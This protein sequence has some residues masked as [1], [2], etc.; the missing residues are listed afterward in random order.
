MLSLTKNF[1]FKKHIG[2]K[3]KVY[4]ISFDQERWNLFCK[5]LGVD[6]KDAKDSRSIP[7]LVTACRFGEF[8]L[9]EDFGGVMSSVL[10]AEQEYQF[11]G[12]FKP[13][14]ILEYQ[15]TLENVLERSGKGAKLHFMVFKTSV[16]TE[17]SGEIAICGSTL[18]YREL[19]T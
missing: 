11:K 6:P 10:H 4:H 17:R 15:T 5:V 3:S 19:L 16:K 18:V 12:E 9:I 2:A 13:G 1:D 8:D 7:T 14:E